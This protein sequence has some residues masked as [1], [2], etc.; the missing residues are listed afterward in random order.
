MIQDAQNALS[1]QGYDPGAHDGHIGWRTRE[2][3]RNFQRDKGLPISGVLDE[4]TADR[5]GIR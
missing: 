2:A 5:L 4:P 3:I 1:D